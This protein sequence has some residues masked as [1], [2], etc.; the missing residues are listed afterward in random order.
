MAMTG[1]VL[2]L[3]LGCLVVR[4]GL[5]L[6]DARPYEGAATERSYIVVAV[7]AMIVWWGGSGISIFLAVRAQRRS[8]SHRE[9]AP[10]EP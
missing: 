9:Q 6:S 8:G 4:F 2:S 5:A 7:L 3:V 1:S 10:Q